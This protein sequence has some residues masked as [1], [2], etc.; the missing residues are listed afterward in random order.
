MFWRKKYDAGRCVELFGAPTGV[1]SVGSVR[2]VELFG[3]P[4]GVVL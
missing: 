1:A 4:T 3:A 2:C